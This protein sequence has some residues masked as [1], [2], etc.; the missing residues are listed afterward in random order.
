MASHGFTLLPSGLTVYSD[1][2]ICWKI[3]IDSLSN[4]SMFCMPSDSWVRAITMSPPVCGDP[5]DCDPPLPLLLLPPPQLTSR[6]TAAI[7]AMTSA[8][9]RFITPQCQFGSWVM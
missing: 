9:R 1:S 8:R 6:T 2:N 7:I 5:A 4:T 3:Q